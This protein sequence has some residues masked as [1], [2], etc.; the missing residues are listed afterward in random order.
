[1]FSLIFNAVL[2]CPA[3][4]RRSPRSRRRHQGN[5]SLPDTDR[6]TDRERLL[7]DHSATYR[8][9]PGLNNVAYMSDPELPPDQGSPSPT[10]EVFDHGPPP[11]PYVPP[12]PSI[13]EARQQMHSLLDDAFALVSPSS[14]GSVSIGVAQVSPAQP[15]PL[16]SPQT[17]PARQWASSYLAHSPFSAGGAIV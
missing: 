7:T 15:S 10:D 9:Y 16:P 1:M 8:K 3:R 12:Q 17:R 6:L 2:S 5:G 11:P 4:G 13:E 14:Q